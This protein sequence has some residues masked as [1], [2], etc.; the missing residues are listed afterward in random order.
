MGIELF[1][2]EAL[3]EDAI[4]IFSKVLAF[5]NLLDDK[6]TPSALNEEL[7]LHE[8]YGLSSGQ[9]FKEDSYIDRKKV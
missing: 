2:I 3:H 5:V 1:R 8:N 7:G 9:L 4:T 6:V